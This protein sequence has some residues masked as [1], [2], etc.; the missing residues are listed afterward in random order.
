MSEGTKKLKSKKELGSLI[1]KLKTNRKKYNGKTIV[2]PEGTCGR[3]CGSQDILKAVKDALKEENLEGINVRTSGCIGYCSQEP[4]LLILPEG[5]FYPKVDPARVKDIVSN[6]VK[7]GKVINELLWNDPVSKKAIVKINDIPFYK[8]QIRVI[9]GNNELIDPTEIEDYMSIGGYEGLKSALDMNPDKIIEDIKESGLRGRG[10]AGFST[11]LKWEFAKK[12]TGQPKYVI[13]NA[14]EGDPGAFMDRSILEGNP[15]MVLEGMLIGAHAIGASKGYIYVRKEYPLATKNVEIAIKQMYEY[16]LLGN[17]ILGTDFSFDLKISRGAGAFVCGE[18]TALMASIEGR[19]GEPR[20]RPPYPAQSG[21]WGKPTNINNVKSWANVS[22][23]LRNGVKKYRQLGTK[24]SPGSMIFSVVGKI[25]NTGLVEVPMG[26]SLR[27]IIYDIGGGVLNGKKFKAVQTGGPSGGC[28]PEEKLDLPVDYDSLIETG[29]MM[30]S[31][32]MI[33]MDENTCMVD[34][35]KYF[36]NFLKDESCGKCTPCREGLDQM[37]RT[38][39]KITEGKGKEGDIDLLTELAEAVKDTSLC[40]LGKT[41]PN[42][43]IT[44]LRYFKHEYEAHIKDKKCPA[45]ACKTLITYNIKGDKCTGCQL[46]VKNCPVGAIRGEKKNI[47]IIDNKTCIK[48]GL[49]YQVCKFDA[50]EVD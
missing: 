49:C 34:V 29:A 13:C 38:L 40:Q 25:N 39:T 6:T 42:P 31:G 17:K 37:H 2:I 41:A 19:S 12:A 3:A 18:E 9:S 16:G 48:C 45:H 24:N 21:L 7:N 50:V 32:G 35:A 11:G 26:I 1:D 36:V 20:P 44:T 46:C 5:I 47:H 22:Y 10:G 30:G 8:N 28:I 4:I 15:H 27:N 23:I 14:D 33:V 43:I